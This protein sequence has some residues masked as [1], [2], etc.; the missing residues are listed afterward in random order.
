MYLLKG[1]NVSLVDLRYGLI[2]F[3]IFSKINQKQSGVSDLERSRD[4]SA[5]PFSSSMTLSKNAVY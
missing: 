3:T 2:L 4:T 5:H 1:F